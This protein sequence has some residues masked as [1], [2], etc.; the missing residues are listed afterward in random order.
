MPPEPSVVTRF[1]PS[2]T[3]HLHI[4]GARTALFCWA[5]AHSPAA[6]GRGRFLLRIEDTDLARSSEAAARSIMEDLAWLGIVWDDG[7]TFDVPADWHDGSRQECIGGDDRGVGPFFQSQRLHLYNRYIEELIE[8][9]RAYPAFESPEEL[10]AQR[11]AALARRQ[12]YRYDRAALKIPP[13]ERRRRMAAGEPHVVRFRAPDEGITVHDVILGDVSFQPGEM[14]DFV[15]RKADGLPT[16]HFAVVVDD[17]LMGVT[18]VL[19]AQEHLIN[20]P[21]HVALQRALGFRTPVYAHLPLILN[22]DGS[23]MSKRDTD[24][25]V[26]LALRRRQIRELPDGLSQVLADAGLSLTA[27]EFRRW[28]QDPERQLSPPTLKV[29]ARWLGV[30]VPE[31]DVE[32]FRAS[33][34]VPEAIVNFLALLGWSPGLKDARGRDV[35]KFDA[36][37]LAEH[38]SLDRVGRA[39]ARFDRTKLAAFNQEYLRSMTPDRFRTRFERWCVRYAPHVLARLEPEQFAL[40]AQV[41]QPRCRTFAHAVE[42]ARWT[43]LADDAIPYDPAAVEQY[44]RADASRGLSVLRQVRGVL[45][46]LDPFTP[47]AIH[48]AVES[49]CASRGL[50]VG[51]VAQPLRVAVTGT[52]VSPPLGETLAILGRNATLARIDRC[53]ER[54]AS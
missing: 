21:R 32:D 46:S 27:D 15:L 42:L 17:E 22:M 3:G 4:G 16:Y 31:I 33:G 25:A 47:Q 7:P 18:H 5:F 34:Y 37:F 14:D 29:I 28:V 51:A 8:R 24:K 1:A 48:R 10:D 13:D 12:T 9:G 26:R 45:E 36:Q 20:T 30:S 54:C 35:E 44:L 41:L 6:R 53:L 49:F 43:L 23:K 40:L 19:R 38:F 2:P 11:R 50:E 52:A 39:G